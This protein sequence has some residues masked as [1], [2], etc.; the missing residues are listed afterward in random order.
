MAGIKFYKTETNYINLLERPVLKQ[1][2]IVIDKYVLT[3]Q[4]LFKTITS[5][6]LSSSSVNS[7]YFTFGLRN[8]YF[9][10]IFSCILLFA[11]FMHF[12]QIITVTFILEYLW[13]HSIFYPLHCM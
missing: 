6:L 4:L 10:S 9:A 12:L 11:F 2:L 1:P 7:S 3:G 13:L 5:V 8:N